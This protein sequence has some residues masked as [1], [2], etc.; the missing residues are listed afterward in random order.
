MS[1]PPTPGRAWVFGDNIDTDALA[2]GLYMKG[3]IEELAAHCLGTVDANFAASVNPGDFVIAGRNFGM[4]SSREQ[5]AQALKYLGVAAVI[6]Q[7]FAGIFYRNALN[8]GLPALICSGA[9]Q[10]L[11]GDQLLVDLAGGIVE[12]MTRKETLAC[13]PLPPHLLSLVNDGGLVPHL[14]KRFKKT[15]NT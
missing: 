2:P 12:N 13:E 10:I 14:E 5:A 8:L 1:T 3:P 7:S 4:G 11:S 6:A 9:P 15:G